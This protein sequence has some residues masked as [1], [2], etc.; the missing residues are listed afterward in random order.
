MT[1]NYIKNNK[2]LYEEQKSKIMLIIFLSKKTLPLCMKM[3]ETWKVILKANPITMVK[4]LDFFSD[5]KFSKV[6]KNE[7][8]GTDWDIFICKLLFFCNNWVE[9]QIFVMNDSTSNN[10]SISYF[11]KLKSVFMIAFHAIALKKL[12]Y[13]AEVVLLT[14]F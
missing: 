14:P 9:I 2:I 6:I 4:L 5:T 12:K 10:P 1:N 11:F 13:L 3:P 8:I 7:L